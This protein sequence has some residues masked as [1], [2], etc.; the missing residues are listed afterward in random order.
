M[1]REQYDRWKDFALRMARTCF[2][3]R[4]KPTP[5]QIVEMVDEFFEWME[6]GC[7][8]GEF[9][10]Y[11]PTIQDWDHCTEWPEEGQRRYGRWPEPIC[12][13]VSCMAEHWIPGYWGIDDDKYEDVRDKWMGPATSCIRAGLDLAAAP[14][15]GVVGFTA[16]DIRRMYPEGVPD[17]IARQWDDAE[18]I[19]VEAVVP[20]V[21]F[22]PKVTGKSPRFEDIADDQGV[23]L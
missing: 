17:W 23:W 12:D 1:T 9:T 3:R 15:A 20:G 8:A 21:G 13:F 4:R 10:I 22:I 18:M 2:R 19:G 14:S 5:K 11:L 16:G 7:H 6:S